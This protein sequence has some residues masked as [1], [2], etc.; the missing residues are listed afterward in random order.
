[1]VSHRCKKSLK[2]KKSIRKDKDK[3]HKNWWLYN[4]EEDWEW[5]CWILHPITQINY[6]PFCGK[7]LDLNKKDH[8][9]LERIKAGLGI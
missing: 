9:E 2:A 8:L 6:C 4:P 1:M 3:W 7:P 5:D